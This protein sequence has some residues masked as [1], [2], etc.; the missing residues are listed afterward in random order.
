MGT[1][2]TSKGKGDRTR[3]Q[4]PIE[5]PASI[6]APRVLPPAVGDGKA[7]VSPEERREMVRLA[8]YLRA[9]S[10]GFQGGSELEDWLAAEA[11]ID[12]QLG[13]PRTD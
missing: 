12:R 10:R 1:K 3:L 2:Q 4:R 5:P 13:A 6:E 11:E 8:A 7:T 9:E